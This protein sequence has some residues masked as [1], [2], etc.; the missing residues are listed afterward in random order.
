MWEG[1]RAIKDAFYISWLLLT[2]HS[3]REVYQR[4]TGDDPD[5]AA[6]QEEMYSR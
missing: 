1:M 4:V 6:S 3:A 2:G 5:Q